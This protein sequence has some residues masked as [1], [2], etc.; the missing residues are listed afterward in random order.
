MQNLLPKQIMDTESGIW[1]DKTIADKLMYIPNDDNQ[2]YPFCR[3]KLVI[4]MFEHST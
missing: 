1:K 2:T 3:L 4:E